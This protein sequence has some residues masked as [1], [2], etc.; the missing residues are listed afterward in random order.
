M[1]LW[2]TLLAGV[3]TYHLV[4]PQTLDA[5]PIR[6]LAP[7]ATLTAVAWQEGASA[8]VSVLGPGTNADLEGWRAVVREFT[9]RTGW[10][11]DL[12]STPD[13]ASVLSARAEE[14]A[15]P[16]IAVVP[17]VALVECYARAG[18]LVP[19]ER[20]LDVEALRAQYPPGWLE[21]GAVQGQLYGL[22]YRAVNKSIVWYDPG[23]FQRR[24]WT[25]PLTWRDLVRLGERIAGNGLAPW[26]LGLDRG[27]LGTD[28]IENIL[29]RT[30]GPEVYDRWVRHEIPWTHP[31]LREAFLRWAEIVG[32]P[33]NLWGGPPGA[34][35]RQGDQAVEALYQEIPEAYLD[36]DGSWVQ[37]RI[38]DRF[39]S[40]RPGEDYDFFPLPAMSLEESVPVLAGADVL[41][42]FNETAPAVALLRY[43]ATG[44]AQAVTV[45]RGGSIAPHRSVR[46][47]DYP[48]PLSRRAARQL[49][50]AEVVRFDGSD[51][52]PPAVERA[53]R[54]AVAEFVANPGRLETILADLERVA[55]EAYGNAPGGCPGG[56]PTM[57]P[58]QGGPAP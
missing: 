3:V 12:E 19:L 34:L 28:W 14:G 53:F 51:Q 46:L 29:L 37:P 33:R 6:A 9:Q 21:L 18:K 41:V 30:G 38:A 1:L 40:Q 22:I 48:D 15:P 27:A 39:P 23:E 42:L 2:L 17:G 58:P 11:V 47:A 45:E 13:V 5:N 31:A 44:E 24:K 10:T 16:D 36:L 4:G 57:G 8:R 26:A 56:T 55:R 20:V 32:R 35:G 50:E 7:S 43:L 52:M 25:V 54:Q 49:L